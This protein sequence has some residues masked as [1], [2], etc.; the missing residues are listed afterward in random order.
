MAEATGLVVVQ[1]THNITDAARGPDGRWILPVDRTDEA[2]RVLEKKILT[3]KAIIMAAGSL[4]PP[5]CS[6]AP[7]PRGWYRICPTN[8]A[9]A[10]EPTP[11]GSTPGP[12][13]PR[14]SV[15]NRADL[16]Y[17][18]LNWRDPATAHT[19]IQASIPPLGMDP[20][21]D[22][23]RRSGRT[24]HGQPGR[25]GGGVGHLTAAGP[26]TAGPTRVRG[27]ANRPAASRTGSN[28]NSRT[29]SGRDRAPRPE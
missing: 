7:A 25:S 17:G 23:H 20:H 22:D 21:F 27:C 14:T 11:T 5:T 2:A 3:A 16:V 9:R 18:S 10:G 6:C 26:G 13:W 24:S 1:V 12:T 29:R 28:L 15:P 19:V 8:S 4:P